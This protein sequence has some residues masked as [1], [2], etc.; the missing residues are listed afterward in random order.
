MDLVWLDGLWWIHKSYHKLNG[1]VALAWH[2]G[3]RSGFTYNP[4]CS[5]GVLIIFK[6]LSLVINIGC[7][8]NIVH[9]IVLFFVNYTFIKLYW[10]IDD[11]NW[12]DATLILI[13]IVKG[14]LSSNNSTLW[15]MTW[16]LCCVLRYYFEGY[17]YG[18]K[19]AI[20][21]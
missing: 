4:T 8:N 3:G 15:Y 16:S 11:P 18:K 7:F 20:I 14:L 13:F 2:G 17:Y 6:I 10:K 21:C 19:L 12:D 1:D 5:H 9:I